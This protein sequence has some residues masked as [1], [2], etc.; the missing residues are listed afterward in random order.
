MSQANKAVVRKFF[1]LLE[2]EQAIPESLLGSGF[3]YHVAGSPPLDLEASRERMVM[4]STGFSDIKHLIEDM[5]AEGDLV[6]FRSRLEMVHT[7]EF[8]GVAGSNK[9]ISVVEMGVMRIANGKV[10]EMW[11][12]LD[13]V[14]IMKQL[15]LIPVQG[16]PKSSD[17]LHTVL[18]K[19]DLTFSQ[20]EVN[21][22]AELF[23][24]D[25]RMLWPGRDD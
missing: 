7:G 1:E 4:F 17:S 24:E 5:V 8:M 16:S 14:E 11:G 13:S 2:R 19:L 23:A 15:G 6:A 22:V 9:R 18:S 12:I 10:A 25:A 20:G 21:E 3:V